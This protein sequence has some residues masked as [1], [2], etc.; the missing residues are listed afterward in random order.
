M[1]LPQLY[2]NLSLVFV[3]AALLAILGLRISTGT[4][5]Q[6]IELIRRFRSS[7]EHTTR[8]CM[9]ARSAALA[10]EFDVHDQGGCERD[11]NVV[12]L[13][14]NRPILRHYVE[15]SDRLIR[16]LAS[17]SRDSDNMRLSQLRRRLKELKRVQLESAR[18]LSALA[19]DMNYST[20]E[21]PEQYHAYGSKLQT[22]L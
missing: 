1:D 8:N 10:R 9:L 4:T 7:L 21:A 6:Q 5:A 14:S 15:E 18:I 2:N 13:A 17:L 3:A 11:T 20:T 19:T 22:S 16:A 12:L